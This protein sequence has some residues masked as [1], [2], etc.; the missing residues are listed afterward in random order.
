VVGGGNSAGQAAVHLAK[1][2]RRVTVL[3]RRTTLAETM[4]AYL[5]DEI[6]GQLNIDVRYETEIVDGSGD[7][8]LESLTLKNAGSGELEV[9]PA[10][11]VF[12]LIGAQPRTGWL[13]DQIDRDRY[14][15]V[16][17]GQASPAWPLDRPPFM[18]ESTM[19]GVFAVGDV[20]AGSVKRVASAAGEGSVAIQQVHEYLQSVESY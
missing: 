17:T 8:A 20:R 13:P 9:V 3:V 5:I 18:F 16:V 1:H 7:G 12:I 15:F 4:S 10:D 11:A 2:A 19:P 14:G 6:E